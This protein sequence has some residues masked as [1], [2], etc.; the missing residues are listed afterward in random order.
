[1]TQQCYQDQKSH[2]GSSLG[3]LGCLQ[4][5]IITINEV[6][7]QKWPELMLA[8]WALCQL[9][10]KCSQEVLPKDYNVFEETL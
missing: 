2:E 8:C 7:M 6:F 4:I 5:K 3:A 1:M 10:R 9:S